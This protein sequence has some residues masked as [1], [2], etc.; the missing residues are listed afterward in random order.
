MGR[1]TLLIVDDVDINRDILSSIL[2]EDYRI[3]TADDGVKAIDA[4]DS[5][6]DRLVAI[7]LDLVMPEKDG[8]AVLREMKERDLL[9]NVP[10]L[11]ISSEDSRA[12]EK[13]CFAAGVSDFIHKPFD[14]DLVRMRVGNAVNLFMYRCHLEDKIEEQ[15]RVIQKRNSNTLDLLASVVETRDLESGAHVLR[16]KE[17]TRIIAEELKA[18]FPK[19]GLNDH[20][21]EVI[22]AASALHDVG[23]IAI[24]DSILLKPGKLTDDEFTE[25][26]TH[27]TRGADFIMRVK[28]MWDEEYSEAG[29]EIAKYHHEKYGGKGYPE[30]LAGDEIPIAAQIV[31]IAD[32][33]DALISKRCYKAAFEKREAYDMI[34]NGECGAFNP[35]IL[36]CFKSRVN[37]FEK[38][39]DIRG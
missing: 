29:Y 35:D 34:M 3:I 30:G 24:S 23:K 37:D 1:D 14:R 12:T 20:K 7:L 5:E 10:V 39:A 36:E 18:R 2:E 26:K 15:T 6:G 22:V 4:I 25:M 8:Y 28:D 38:Y 21:V 27:T 17:Y 33:Y 31:S 16:V 11:I 9:F 13:E 19:Y 32:V